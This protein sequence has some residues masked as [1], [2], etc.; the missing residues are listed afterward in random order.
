MRILDGTMELP[1]ENPFQATVGVNIKFPYRLKKTVV[2]RRPNVLKTVTV[3]RFYGVHTVTIF[4]RHFSSN[5][6]QIH[7]L[8]EQK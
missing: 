1:P 8:E 2:L 6:A 4:T 7:Q 3:C 5:S